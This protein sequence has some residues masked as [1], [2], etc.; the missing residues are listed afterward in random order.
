M[1]MMMKKKMNLQSRRKAPPTALIR[2]L[3]AKARRRSVAPTERQ[4][5]PLSPR[6]WD[7]LA[8]W[9]K[10]TGQTLIH[11]KIAVFVERRF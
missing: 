6:A 8:G 3:P 4:T 11:M 5:F 2:I 9:K 10:K 7:L 1:M